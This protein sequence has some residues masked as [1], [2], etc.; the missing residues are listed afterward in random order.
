MRRPLLPFSFSETILPLRNL[1]WSSVLFNSQFDIIFWSQLPV[2][3][4]LYGSCGEY[5][6]NLVVDTPWVLRRIH[7]ESCHMIASH[8]YL[9]SI[10]QEHNVNR[11]LL[12]T[13]DSS[14]SCV[15][16]IRSVELSSTWLWNTWYLRKEYWLSDRG[17]SP[18][19]GNSNKCFDML[20][21]GNGWATRVFTT[22]VLT[23][24]AAIT[25]LVLS[26]FRIDI[27]L[28]S[29]MYM[30]SKQN[31]RWLQQCIWQ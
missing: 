8:M 14:R 24:F 18:V 29:L 28:W 7:H 19:A 22:E 11:L 20:I 10:K 27:L 2:E 30:C 13:I 16:T 21:H 31:T 23:M 5:T 4:E 1:L 12:L 3:D 17:F 6:M 26:G 9:L 25:L 15:E